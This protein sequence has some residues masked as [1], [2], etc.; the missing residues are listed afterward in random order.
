MQDSLTIMSW[1][2]N[3]ETAVSDSQLQGQLTFLEEHCT[4]VDIFLFQAVRNE[5][6]ENGEWDVHLETF[7]EY[8]KNHSKEYDVAHT[9][10]WSR[11]LME[12]DVQPHTDISATHNRCNV[13]VSRWPIARQPLDLRN[14]GDR[15]PQKL[16][17][18]YSHFPEKMLVATIDTS[19]DDSIEAETVEVWNVGIINGAHWGEEKINMLETVYGRIYLQNKK[20]DRPLILGGDFNAPKE[21]TS[22]K[23]I[24]P[25]DKAA[26]THYPSYGDP[27]Y[28]HENGEDMV[29]HT[30]GQRWRT[31]EQ[32]L[33]DH[34]LG[35]W[36]MQDAYLESPT[37]GYEASTEEYTHIIHNGNPSKK[38]LDHI[39]V[40]DAFTVRGCEIWNGR[41]RS[42]DGLNGEGIYMSDHAPVI[43][44][45][46]IES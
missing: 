25:H 10:D 30:F 9:G 41:D 39:L 2:V 46:V 27:Y 4:D 28:F 12:S 14:I 43:A 26:Y 36:D 32:Q 7:L 34:E 42:L 18:Y 6:A 23:Q 20:M 16:N 5:T 35:E 3:G 22:D 40:L 33:F 37:E 44:E 19:G 31:A 21:E 8:F 17:Y 45:V 38:R 29:K 1:N 11:E 24:I 15:K 13:T